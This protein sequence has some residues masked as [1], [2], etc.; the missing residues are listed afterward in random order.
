MELSV[1][2]SEHVDKAQKCFAVLKHTLESWCRD[3]GG[4][5]VKSIVEALVV[6]VKQLPRENPGYKDT[7]L[8]TS[9]PKSKA[10]T[11]LHILCVREKSGDG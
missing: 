11:V 7:P 9:A 1:A 4:L 3:P 10:R 8:A 5:L 2:R 6:T